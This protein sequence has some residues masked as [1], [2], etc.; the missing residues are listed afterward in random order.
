MA[1]DRLVRVERSQRGFGWKGGAGGHLEN[2][3]K[4]PG[5]I[6]GPEMD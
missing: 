3:Q 5:E 6:W 4:A 2:D 1:G